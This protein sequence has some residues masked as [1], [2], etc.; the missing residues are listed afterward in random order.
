MDKTQ[1]CIWTGKRDARVMPVTLNTLD[2]F[3]V[4]TERTYYVL[5]EYEQ[6]LRDF[7]DRFVKQGRLFLVLIIGL[8]L[9]LPASVLVSLIT[10]FPES[11]I[12]LSVGGITVLIGGVIVLFPFATPE[13]AKWL[14]L[15][16]AMTAARLAGLFTILLG[17]A[18]CFL[19]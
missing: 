16:R 15:K 2:R 18:I 9:I 4:P 17:I 14:G 13:T 3:T 10:S 11:I 1:K 5:P 8:T 7:N 6:S 19:I 12:L